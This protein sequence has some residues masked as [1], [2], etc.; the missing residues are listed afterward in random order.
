MLYH[1]AAGLVSGA[2]MCFSGRG[3][4]V[5][6]LPGARNQFVQICALLSRAPRYYGLYRQPTVSCRVLR[7]ALM[8]WWPV[9]RCTATGPS[10]LPVVVNFIEGARIAGAF[11]S[12]PLATHP[13]ARRRFLVCLK[14]KRVGLLFQWTLVMEWWS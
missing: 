10:W 1:M 9:L 12:C 4:G 14:S 2:G 6:H 8:D 7:C 3:E 13:N 5:L 11:F